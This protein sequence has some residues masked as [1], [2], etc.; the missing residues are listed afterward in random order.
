MQSISWTPLISILPFIFQNAEL[1]PVK[2]WP[3]TWTRQ[4]INCRRHDRIREKIRKRTGVTPFGIAPPAKYSLLYNHFD[5]GSFGRAG[6]MLCPYYET[7]DGTCTIWN[8]REATC[9]TFFC[10][11]VTGQDGF[12]FW[13][14]FKEYLAI[15]Q[16]TLVSYVLYCLGFEALLNTDFHSKDLLTREDLDNLPLDEH[17]YGSIWK[18]WTG[19]EDEFYVRS[20]D[21]VTNLSAHE[22][23]SI[24][25]RRQR[26][27]LRRLHAMRQQMM[28]SKVPS[29]LKVS[30]QLVASRLEKGEYLL[31]TESSYYQVPANRSPRA[32]IL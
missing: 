17:A 24:A 15:V 23:E 31:T 10:K 3:V 11:P 1:L 26:I 21:L 30:P 16:A 2:W 6:S 4:R 20:Y 8:Y 12:A 29:V 13:K 5:S 18:N 7:K 22:F 27:L 19:R 32:A 14:T 9:A 25:D 28:K